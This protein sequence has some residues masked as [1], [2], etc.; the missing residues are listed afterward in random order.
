MKKSKRTAEEEG[1][2]GFDVYAK[3][4]PSPDAPPYIAPVTNSPLVNLSVETLAKIYTDFTSPVKVQQPLLEGTII[5][6][7]ILVTY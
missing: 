3:D 7:S 5:A 1:V 4:G 6:L 2:D